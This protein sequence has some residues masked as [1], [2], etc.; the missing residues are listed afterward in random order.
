M[1]VKQQQ[2]LDRIEASIDEIEMWLHDR[3][4]SKRF[5]PRLKSIHV[6]PSERHVCGWGASV[7]G[8]FTHAEQ[9]ESRAAVVELQRHFSFRA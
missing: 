8:E 4:R 7:R 2:T 6:R 3:L 5:Y 1:T 9:D